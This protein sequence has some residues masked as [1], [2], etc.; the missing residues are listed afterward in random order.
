MTLGRI[1]LALALT[2]AAACTTGGS[3]PASSPNLTQGEAVGCPLGVSGTTVT[4]GD[5]TDGIVLTFLAPEKVGD[6]RERVVD[7]AAFHGPGTKYGKGHDGAH[8]S[9]GDH[10]L[11]LA[12]IPPV[13]ARAENVEGGAR[14]TFVPKD[15]SD[16]ATVR[17]KLRERAASMTASTCK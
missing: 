16:L 11:Q 14:I 9:G 6:I 8:G 15:A 13:T 5:V 1:A 7:A 3:L 12:T 10:G 4:A 2:G 17:T